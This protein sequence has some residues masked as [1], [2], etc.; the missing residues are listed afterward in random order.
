MIVTPT[1]S[2][3]DVAITVLFILGVLVFATA[4]IT[5]V[6]YL[7]IRGYRVSEPPPDLSPEESIRRITELL[8]QDKVVCLETIQPEFAVWLRSCYPWPLSWICRKRIEREL[9]KPF[10][11]IQS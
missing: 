9:K 10:D 4:W 1:P 7:L 2:T 5:V 11:G 6:M 3:L 8:E